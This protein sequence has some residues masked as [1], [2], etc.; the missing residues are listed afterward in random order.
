MI[1]FVLLLCRQIFFGTLLL[2][3]IVIGSA[4][5][6]GNII[7]HIDAYN[8]PNMYI[9]D[10]KPSGLYANIIK[11]ISEQMGQPIDIVAV[12][13][14]RALEA[15]QI[16]VG[17][18]GGFYKTP[19]RSALFDY[20]HEIYAEQL[21]V[22]VK[23]GHQFEFKGI[24]D[25][26]GKKIGVILG[27]SYGTNFDTAQ[28]N[29]ALKVFPV[30]RDELNFKKLDEGRL[31]CVIASRESGLYQIT[32]GGY[33]DIYPLEKAVLV[34]PTYVAFSKQSQMLH[35]LSRFNVALQKM[36]SSGKLLEIIEQ[37]YKEQ[38]GVTLKQFAEPRD[39]S[40]HTTP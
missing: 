26:E 8:P 35:F 17:G 15:A 40:P 24:P 21:R 39:S 18:I 2:P 22:F 16:G 7:V 10:G 38:L 12:P 30:N 23:R 31:D 4:D 27:W 25:L 13:W 11:A 5:A 14:K 37:F 20:S 36:E 29:G 33:A 32:A 19:E 3:F 34:N 6:A 9:E 1:D 28:K